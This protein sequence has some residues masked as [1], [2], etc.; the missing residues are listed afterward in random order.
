MRPQVEAEDAVVELLEAPAVPAQAERVIIAALDV[1]RGSPLLAEQPAIVVVA[2]IGVSADAEAADRA[3]VPLPGV[4]Q[5]R[6]SPSVVGERDEAQIVPE[7]GT[8]VVGHE[9]R[10]PAR[11]LIG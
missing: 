3:P 8:D 10:E 7:I 2:V 4:L 1:D 9:L 11:T 5:V 6:G